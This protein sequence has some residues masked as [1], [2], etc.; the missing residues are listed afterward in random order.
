MDN[1]NFIPSCVDP[2]FT[3]WERQG[4]K[5]IHDLYVGKTIRSFRQLQD[6]FKLSNN[7]FFRYLQIRIFLNS[8]P[9]Y[10]Q[11]DGPHS[12]EKLLFQIH[13]QKK[14]KISYIY[15]QLLVLS[16]LNTQSSKR[17]WEILGTKISDKQWK[18]IM[19]NSKKICCNYKSQE[20]Q[21]KIIHKLQ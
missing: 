10:K 11:G 6:K 18:S 14:K 4:I 2:G 12:L 13:L 3:E 7:I 19:L 1:S 8:I 15:N 21:F 17:S 9:Q 5:V 20:T 16:N